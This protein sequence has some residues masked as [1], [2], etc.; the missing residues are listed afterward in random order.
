MDE[1]LGVSDSCS[2]AVGAIIRQLHFSPDSVEQ[3]ST[4]RSRHT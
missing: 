3:S 1:T 4:S 2:F